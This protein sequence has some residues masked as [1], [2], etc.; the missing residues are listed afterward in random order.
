MTYFLFDSCFFVSL[1]TKTLHACWHDVIISTILDFTILSEGQQNSKLMECYPKWCKGV[2]RY[3]LYNHFFSENLKKKPREFYYGRLNLAWPAC[4][5]VVAMSNDMVSGDTTQ[6]RGQNLGE[7]SIVNLLIKILRNTSPVSPWV[8]SLRHYSIAVSVEILFTSQ[9]SMSAHWQDFLVFSAFQVGWIPQTFIRFNYFMIRSRSRGS[10]ARPVHIRSKKFWNA[11]LFV[12]YV[13][14]R[15]FLKTNSIGRNFKTLALR[16][17]NRAFPKRWRQE[18][19]PSYPSFPQPQIHLMTY[20]AVTFQISL[21][22]CRRNWKTLDA[23]PE[24]KHRFLLWS[25]YVWKGP[26][27]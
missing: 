20:P 14:K 18:R 7:F 23:L 21:T 8:N 10:K 27:M 22:H 11:A 17:L 1:L 9:A 5:N 13:A 19:F 16:E 6:A 24:V 12:R 2:K 15:R 3:R 26:E 25:G 4:Q